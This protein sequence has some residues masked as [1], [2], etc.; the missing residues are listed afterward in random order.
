MT[1]P[2]GP[3]RYLFFPCRGGEIGRRDGLKI[4]YWQ[5]CAGSTP[6]PGTKNFS[7]LASR[8]PNDSS[9]TCHFAPLSLPL[10]PGLPWSEREP[11]RR[12]ERVVP[13][14]CKTFET[15]VCAEGWLGRSSPN[16]CEQL[17]FAQGSRVHAPRNT[18]RFFRVRPSTLILLPQRTAPFV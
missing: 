17:C 16:G 2:A 14:S 12:S 6:A 18:D 7:N 3:R 8:F 10:A 1:R 5:Q 4:R 15:K 13:C 9:L 11:W